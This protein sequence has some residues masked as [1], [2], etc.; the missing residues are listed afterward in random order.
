MVNG[1]NSTI[2]D[3]AAAAGVSVATVSRVFNGS[4]LVTGK[5]AEK[6]KKIAAELDYYPNSNARGLSVSKNEIIGFILPVVYGEF[7]S[8]LI[9]SAET[10]IQKR[11]YHLIISSVHDSVDELRDAIRSLR[12][13]VD[14]L[15][16]FF[17]YKIDE[18]ILGRLTEKMPV[19]F[20]SDFTKKKIAN[21]ITIDNFE[22]SRK[23]TEQIIRMGHRRIAYFR[24]DQKNLDACD[25]FKGFMRAVEDNS[26]DI[27][28][29]KIYDAGFT[30]AA[31]RATAS[32]LA[33][34]SFKPS[35]II[36]ANDACAIGALRYFRENNVSVPDELSIAGFDDIETASLL[37]P[38]L[39]TV[40]GNIRSLA[41]TAVEHLFNMITSPEKIKSS[42][43]TVIHAAP[44]LRGSVKILN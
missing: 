18:K 19:I 32:V 37:Y 44:V 22:G 17:P 20:L 39:T 33:A 21:I 15:A 13:K 8:E 40:N 26:S 35:V 42:G 2:Y 27:D 7:F 11:K 6:I 10:E 31:G 12:S 30:R 41:V 4:P 24:A 1:K 5:T 9:Y 38:Q 29:Y 25:R 36:C 28:E 43:K 34:G 16:I 14:A 3:V 23:L